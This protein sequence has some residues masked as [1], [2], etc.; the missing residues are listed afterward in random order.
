MH[1]WLSWCQ[2]L[3]KTVAEAVTCPDCCQNL[4]NIGDVTLQEQTK[5]S[6]LAAESN[7]IVC[8]APVVSVALAVPLARLGVVLLIGA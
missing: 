1:Y 2:N 8:A 5:V 6:V 7:V 4:I 3:I